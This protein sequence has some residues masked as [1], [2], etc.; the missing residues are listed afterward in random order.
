MS[1]FRLRNTVFESLENEINPHIVHAVFLEAHKNV[2]YPPIDLFRSL[3]ICAAIFRGRDD[4]A[5]IA[6]KNAENKYDVNYKQGYSSPLPLVAATQMCKYDLIE[7][8]LL[9][10]A[11]VSLP[12]AGTEDDPGAVASALD[13][14][15]K[16]D[17]VTAFRLMKSR[18]ET[19]QLLE[20]ATRHGAYRCAEECLHDQPFAV[21]GCK[22]SSRYSETPTPLV[23][24]LQRRDK[25]MV[26]LLL[27]AGAS[28][29]FSNSDGFTAMHYAADVPHDNIDQMEDIIQLLI[30]HQSDMNAVTCSGETPLSL[31]IARM[32]KAPN[33]E[34]T[35]E[36]STAGHVQAF[37]SRGCLLN[38]IRGKC[39]LEAC[40]SQF[41]S[42]LFRR[43]GSDAVPF[44]RWFDDLLTFL[45]SQGASFSGWDSSAVTI[46][47]ILQGLSDIGTRLLAKSD[48]ARRFKQLVDKIFIR[49]L[50]SHDRLP[51]NDG[52]CGYLTQSSV[53]SRRFLGFPQQTSLISRFECVIVTV[54]MVT[55]PFMHRKRSQFG[56]H[57]FMEKKTI[58]ILQ[59]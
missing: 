2:Q 23:Y 25:R 52:V 22:L 20:M 13:V 15:L 37:V 59:K 28:V 16:L 36:G 3:F 41:T 57:Y 6:L 50:C 31:F 34:S 7:K 24:A 42:C 47:T 11:R 32:L 38:P 10:K 35:H 56:F 26:S 39:A 46:N 45:F 17:D 29:N 12:G 1:I 19:P 9:K 4:V 48:N 54:A 18:S 21:N 5:E 14:A 43:I 30:A 40:Y 27:N 51:F 49:L 8:L 53:L 55:C 44:L 58:L 33:C